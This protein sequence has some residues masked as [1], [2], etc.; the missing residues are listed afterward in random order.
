M[1]DHN[2]YM[3]FGGGFM[4][5]VWLVLLVIV[6]IVIKAVMTDSSNRNDSTEA[7]KE[8]PLEILKR[9]YAAG[10]IDDEEF[11]RRRKNLVK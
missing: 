7:Q 6:V 9:R 1:Y 11:D 5:L 10:E 2:G 8:T 4:W 3:F